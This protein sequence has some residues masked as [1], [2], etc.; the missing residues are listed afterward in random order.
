[1]KKFN[2]RD[3]LGFDGKVK[4]QL[5]RNYVSQG[6]AMFGFIYGLI[7]LFGISSRDV[8][9]TLIL[10]VI[11]SFFCYFAGRYLYKHRWVE[12][13]IEAGNRYNPFVKEMRANMPKIEE[14][15]P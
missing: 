3:W 14:I 8:K 6:K 10:G 11:Y 9:T 2:L 4:L 5:Q 1:M 13:D 12:A 15:K 7:A